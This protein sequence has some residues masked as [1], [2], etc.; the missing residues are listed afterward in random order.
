MEQTQKPLLNQG[1]KPK[2]FQFHIGLVSAVNDVDQRYNS[3]F[4]A[5]WSRSILVIK[6]AKI[7]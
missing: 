2:Y 4:W 1:R 3:V 7:K 5:A 6:A